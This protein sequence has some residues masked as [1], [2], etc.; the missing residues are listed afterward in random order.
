MPA[1]GA[2]ARPV[3]LA[4]LATYTGGD[5][6]LNAEVLALFLDQ[7][8]ILL[9]QLH[10][11]LETRDQT[12]WREITHSLKGAARGIGAFDLADAAAEAEPVGVAENG[13]SALAAIR[14]L[15]SRMRDV[16]RF[17]EAHLGR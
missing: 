10:A 17:I 5:A 6:A 7:S 13:A 1:T 11:V 12:R 15:D 9:S 4:H 8:A 3:D 2:Q 14:A 16:Q